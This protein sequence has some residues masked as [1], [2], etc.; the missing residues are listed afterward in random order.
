MI[1]LAGPNAK[2]SFWAAITGPPTSF[3]YIPVVPLP[4]A[5]RIVITRVVIGPGTSARALGRAEQGRRSRR[6]SAASDEATASSK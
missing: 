1:E 3:T 5:L 4:A 2:F 6:S